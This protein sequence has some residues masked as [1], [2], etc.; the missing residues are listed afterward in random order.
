MGVSPSPS[1]NGREHRKR[2]ATAAGFPPALTVARALSGG[3]PVSGKASTG[4]TGLDEPPG[5]VDL[6]RGGSRMMRR[7]WGK[8]ARVSSLVTKIRSK[9]SALY[10]VVWSI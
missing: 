1:L 2:R 8:E 7:R 10:R 4:A 9:A 6:A 3:A 5:A